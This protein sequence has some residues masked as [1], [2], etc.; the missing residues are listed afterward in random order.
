MMVFECANQGPSVFT[1][2]EDNLTFILPSARVFIL[3]L[4]VLI[5][6]KRRYRHNRINLANLG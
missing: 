2:I 5:S 1:F 6:L 3:V 4:S